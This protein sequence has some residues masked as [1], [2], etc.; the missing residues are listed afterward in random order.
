M[1]RNLSLATHL[2][3]SFVTSGSGSTII[4]RYTLRLLNIKLGEGVD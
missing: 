1:P 3:P 2:N 4:M